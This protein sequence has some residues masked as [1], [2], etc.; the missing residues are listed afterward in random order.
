MTY[1]NMFYFLGYSR[2]YIDYIAKMAN[3]GIKSL[4]Y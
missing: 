4:N 2:Q 1:E 3:T